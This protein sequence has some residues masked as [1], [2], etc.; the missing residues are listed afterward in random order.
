MQSNMQSYTCTLQRALEDAVFER[1]AINAFHVDAAGRQVDVPY[2]RCRHAQGASTQHGTHLL[3]RELVLDMGYASCMRV[4]NLLESCDSELGV[5]VGMSVALVEALLD[6]G[7][8]LKERACPDA[9][10]ASYSLQL[11]CL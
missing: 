8:P 1:M 7:W 5:E 10:W 2:R 4:H 3:R 9:L 11:R 6:N